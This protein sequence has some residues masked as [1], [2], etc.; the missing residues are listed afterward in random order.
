MR[1][2]LRTKQVMLLNMPIPVEYAGSPADVSLEQV[3]LGYIAAVLKEKGHNVFLY[4]AYSRGD[5]ELEINRRIE[6]YN[7]DFLCVSPTYLSWDTMIRAL[8]KAKENK[9]TIKTILGGP[10]VSFEPVL[11]RAL[12]EFNCID[13]LVRGEGEISIVSIVQDPSFENARKIP[14][15]ACR[16]DN[17]RIHLSRELSDQV[18]DLDSLPLPLRDIEPLDSK[19]IRINTSRGCYTE[20]CGCAFCQL[21]TQYPLGWRG[22]SPENVVDE[23]E[24][25]VGKGYKSF[26]CAEGDFLGVSKR[27]I[28][29]AVLIAEQILRRNLN[30]RLRIF[31]GIPQII[32]AEQSDAFSTLRKAGLERIY[33]GVEAGNQD[34][35]E[36]Y[37][38]NITVHQIRT[39]ARIL[40]RR[41]IGLQIGSM[42][43]NPWSDIERLKANATLLTQIDQAHLWFNFAY[44]LG[45]FP[46]TRLLD[47]VEAEGLLLEPIAVVRLG[48]ELVHNYKFKVPYIERVAKVCGKILAE[49]DIIQADRQLITI[50]VLTSDSYEFPSNLTTSPTM[51]S[52]R[53]QCHKI[54]DDLT[55]LNTTT[56]LTLLETCRNKR[57]EKKSANIARK[58]LAEVRRV[59]PEIQKLEGAAK[60]LMP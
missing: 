22:R 38:K 27:G 42:M 58:H 26:I 40:K 50:E 36:L 52:L 5:S 45:L 3:G 2:A 9:S 6:N 12:K 18:E 7:P 48:S 43:F 41:G 30:V 31:G 47:K 44:K 14:G 21:P 11:S 19:S 37:E 25:W 51:S 33:P 16:D 23:L 59:L 39:A 28:H 8:N 55:I 49:D 13:F 60:H 24:F 32:S 10:H 57:S 54:R 17:R 35:L 46:G 53:K 34:D 20:G 1:K 56:F 15:V 4:D 29:R